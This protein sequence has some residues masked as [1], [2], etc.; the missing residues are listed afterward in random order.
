MN[1]LRLSIPPVPRFAQTA[2]SALSMFAGFHRLP[3]QDEENLVFAL[4]EAVANAIQH[5]ATDA[6]IEIKFNMYGDSIVAKV[7][8]RG[9]GFTPPA[10]SVSLPSLFAEAGRGFAI[11]Q[12]CTDFL[13]VASKPGSGTIVTFGRY[14]R[15]PTERAPAS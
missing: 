8:D 10:G 3:K 5:A 15:E 11:M 2:R 14:R 7:R 9:Q 4:G 12:R 13:D 6:A 1:V